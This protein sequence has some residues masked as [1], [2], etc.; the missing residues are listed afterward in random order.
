L[1]VP[2]KKLTKLK[3]IQ[4]NK[5]KTHLLIHWSLTALPLPETIRKV[6][7]RTM[8]TITKTPTLILPGYDII[9]LD[10]PLPDLKYHRLI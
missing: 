8:M 7:P 3:I 2:K 10:P 1:H 4:W 9:Y 5:E 6:L